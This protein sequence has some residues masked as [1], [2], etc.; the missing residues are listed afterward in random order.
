MLFH[1]INSAMTAAENGTLP[2]RLCRVG[3]R[4]LLKKRLQLL[5]SGGVEAQ[6]ERF[7]RFLDDCR[8]S[9]V[10]ELS[11]LANEQ[12]YELPTAFFQKVLGKRL[13]YSCCEWSPGVVALD[14][15]EEAA[16]TTTCERAGICDG[17]DIL[18]LGCGWGSLS[19]W[20]AEQY[21][22]SRI[23]AVSNSRSQRA[24]IRS[25][26]DR[27]NLKNLEVLTA[28]MNT[29]DTD[30][31]FDRVVSV[32]M[33]EHMRNHAELLR[34]ISGWLNPQGRLFVHIFCHRLHS[35]LFETRGDADWMARHFF[36]GGMM[37]GESLLTHYQQHLELKDQWR[38]DG[39]HYERTCNEWLRLLD[40]NT[41]QLRGVFENTYGP[42]RA[43]AWLNRWR[44]FFMACAELF[45]YR[46]GSEWWVSHYL[47]QQRD[48]SLPE[49]S[50]T[51]TGNQRD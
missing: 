13:K 4:R 43:K 12:H 15:A 44:L 31:R 34:R 42:A 14:Q 22:Q 25:Q 32:E 8:E 29:F 49:A 18:E 10:A 46:D 28:D 33:F 21:P 20:M 37:P 30:H 51:L 5:E 47:F 39:R 26:V 9:S 24:Y 27:L 2:D 45:G 16:L 38:W 41:D 3:I 35:Y 48:T 36:S 1:L 6:Q 23:T 40:R 11:G 19:L 7:R 50:E 17:M